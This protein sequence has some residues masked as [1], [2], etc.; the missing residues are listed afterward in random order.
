MSAAGLG[1]CS[2]VIKIMAADSCLS[3]RYLNKDYNVWHTLKV[4]T[5]YV[6]ALD[7]SLAVFLTGVVHKGTLMLQQHFDAVHCP[8]SKREKYMSRLQRQKGKRRE[9][10]DASPAEKLMELCVGNSRYQESNPNREELPLNKTE[11]VQFNINPKN[12]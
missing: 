9:R 4:N 12:N 7:G 2:N 6:D 3:M 11:E 8:G 1:Q 10:A 5:T